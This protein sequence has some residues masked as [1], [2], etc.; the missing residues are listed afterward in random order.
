VPFVWIG[1]LLGARVVYVETL[2]RVDRP[3]LS[4]R[5]AAP[6]VTRTYVQWPELLR[7]I[8]GAR[9]CGTVADRR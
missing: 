9:F 5:L 1:R 7:S 2:A 8:P 4:Y 3:S 6:F